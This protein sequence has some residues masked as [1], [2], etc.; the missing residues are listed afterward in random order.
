MVLLT[1]YSVR[2]KNGPGGPY[3]TRTKYFVTVQ[4]PLGYSYILVG[5]LNGIFLGPGVPFPSHS[6]LLIISSTT[7]LI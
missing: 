7:K 3:F 6:L 5:H 1:K 2:V 4:Y